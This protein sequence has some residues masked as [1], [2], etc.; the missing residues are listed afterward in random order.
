M[1]RFL[2]FKLLKSIVIYRSED[3]AGVISAFPPDEVL[4]WLRSDGP[5]EPMMLPVVKWSRIYQ[6]LAS[7]PNS[8]A[9]SCVMG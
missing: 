3:V 4:S 8:N 6:Q 1:D 7:K 5:M 9:E 2:V